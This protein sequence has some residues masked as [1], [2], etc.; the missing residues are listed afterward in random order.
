VPAMPSVSSTPPPGAPIDP[1]VLGK[2]R[3]MQS[4][5]GPDVVVEVIDLFL[6]MA[7]G[8]LDALRTAAEAGDAAEL[9][10]L[11][12]TLKGSAAQ[13]GAMGLWRLCLR[14]EEI[15][16]VA[17]EPGGELGNPASLLRLLA[18]EMERVR[19]ALEAERSGVAP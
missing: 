11:A 15:A 18:A 16:A 8:R 5:G 19:V 3:R 17:R 4:A 12:H 13:V 6:G 10:R 1:A 7:P 9:G 14:I 2:L